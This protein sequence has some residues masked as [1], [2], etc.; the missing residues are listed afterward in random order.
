MIQKL[1]HLIQKK[2]QDTIDVVED[3]NDLLTRNYDAEKGYLKAAEKVESVELKKYMKNRAQNRYDFGH[4]LKAII[5]GLGGKIYKG[6][7]FKGDAHRLW[8]DF[9]DAVTTGD[10]AIYQECIRGEEK[11]I[12]KYREMLKDDSLPESLR[13]MLSTQLND[14]M[15]AVEDLS[16]IKDT[17]QSS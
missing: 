6:T 9:K 12:E 4:D 5:T 1:F 10:M 13:S 16:V 15:K 3:L 7:S 17:L 14:A 2:M 8:M 11:F